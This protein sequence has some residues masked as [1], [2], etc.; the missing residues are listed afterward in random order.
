MSEIRNGQ[1]QIIKKVKLS[2]IISE[3]EKPSFQRDKDVLRISE[4]KS[5]L[6]LQ[7]KLHEY[8]PFLG[9]ITLGILKEKLYCIDGQHRLSAY[10]DLLSADSEISI[11]VDIRE[12]DDFIQLRDLYKKINQ[13]VVVPD[14]LLYEENQEIMTIIKNGIGNFRQQFDKYFVQKVNSTRANRPNIKENDLADVVFH[15]SVEFNSHQE[16]TQYLVKINQKLVDMTNESI[17][18]LLKKYKELDY[19]DKHEKIC[20]Q[21]Q[22]ARDKDIENPCLLG[23]FK[24]FSYINEKNDFES[25]LFEETF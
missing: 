12:V 17:Y 10:N 16:L 3:I 4:I 7:K 8:Y 22:K 14:Y 18:M 5:Y 1:K 19:V 21:I 20:N 6:I 9:V 23:M 11:L 2:S 24:R 15:S 25:Y 13:C